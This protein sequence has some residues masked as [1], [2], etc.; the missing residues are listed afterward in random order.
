MMTER[1]FSFLPGVEGT[2]C[3]RAGMSGMIIKYTTFIG[4]TGVNITTPKRGG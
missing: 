2:S 4:F 1:S 3:K